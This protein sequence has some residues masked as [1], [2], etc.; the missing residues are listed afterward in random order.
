LHAGSHTI[1]KGSIQSDHVHIEISIPPKYA[2]SQV[3]GYMKGKSA[4]WIART[5]GGRKRNIVGEHFWARG[6]YVS[7]VGKDEAVIRA[8]IEQQTREDQRLDQLRFEQE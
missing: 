2:V 4:I 6:Y 7:T 1:L 8:Y 3:V 5:Y